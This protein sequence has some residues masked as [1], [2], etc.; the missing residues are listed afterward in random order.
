[1]AGDVRRGW[2]K[3]KSPAT[4]GGLQSRFCV[5]RLDGMLNYYKNESDAEPKGVIPMS[6]VTT[7]VASGTAIEVNV[8]YRCFH[9]VAP[10]ATDASDWVRSIEAARVSGNA[11]Q[12][13][14]TD[15]PGCCNHLRE[16]TASIS[17]A[18]AS[19]SRPERG[20]ASVRVSLP[21]AAVPLPMAPPALPKAPSPD[22]RNRAATASRPGVVME[23]FLLKSPPQLSVRR[24]TE[25]TRLQQRWFLLTNRSLQCFND[26]TVSKPLSS[27]PL[28]AIH[29]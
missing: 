2:L 24:M 7:V 14:P 18:E 17:I 15:A 23:G 21:D 29:S 16:A 4:F 26:A 6:A 20:G 5:L 19:G 1:M 9:F 8:G 28:S 13:I 10:T 11:Q 22:A 27:W 3:K 25:E 12:G